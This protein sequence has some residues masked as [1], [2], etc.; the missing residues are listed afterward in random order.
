M[1]LVHARGG[2]VLFHSDG[3]L[4][5]FLDLIVES[6]VD[7]LHPLEPGAMDISRTYRE[8]GERVVICGNVDCAQTLT[9]GE[10]EA[11]RAEVLWLLE[12]IA[13]GGRFMLT[14]SNTIHSQV[15]A[16]TYRAML[17]ALSEY[18]RY[19]I[20]MGRPAGGAAKG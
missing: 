2:H 20:R 17:D 8:Y 12:N 13:P 1:E 3:K 18:G 10:P 16:D 11:A 14:S 7:L 9:F 4:N 15:R 6:G 5:E 19:P